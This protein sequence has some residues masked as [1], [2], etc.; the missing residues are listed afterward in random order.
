MPYYDIHDGQ[1]MSHKHRNIGIKLTV[2]IRHFDCEVK[3]NSL[4]GFDIRT[5][6]N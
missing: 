1:K 3:N 5:L 2:L 4:H 6:E